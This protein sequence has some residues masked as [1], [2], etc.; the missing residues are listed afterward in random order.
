MKVSFVFVVID[1]NIH[2]PSEKL[3]LETLA[4]VFKDYTITLNV[5]SVIECVKLVPCPIHT[6]FLVLCNKLITQ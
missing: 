2:T 6:I 3:S 4:Q 1:A 5:T